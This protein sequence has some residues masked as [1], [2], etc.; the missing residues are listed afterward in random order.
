MGR[1]R[2]GKPING[3]IAIDKPLE[4]TSTAVVTK[5]RRL[6]G[7]AKVGHGGTLDPLAT[8]ILPI[9]MGEATKTVAY[10]MDGAKTYRWRVTWGESRSTDDAEGE[11]TATSDVRPA[12]E[13]ILAALPAFTGD[14]EQVPPAYSAVKIDGRR[15]YDL[16]RKDQQVELKSRIV[17]ID[18]FRLVEATPDWAEFEVGTGKGAY[19]RSLARDLALALGTVGYVSML[20]RTSCGPFH[21][22]NAISLDML[23]EF[24]HSAASANFI[25]PVETALD[26][27]PALALTEEEA[28]RLQSGQSL[29]VLRL[30]ARDTLSSI[31]AGIT[32]RAMAEQRLVALARIEDGEVR[33]VRVLNL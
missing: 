19:I 14:I 31:P 17:R 4:M 24:G 27:I 1:K 10:V 22:G 23:E 33:P 26:D 5:V 6:T 32:M 15:A 20:R 18:S 29:S 25:L 7:A 8:G 3:W 11:V 21:E 30:A 12:T 13:Q 2:T 16:A 28:R 9:A